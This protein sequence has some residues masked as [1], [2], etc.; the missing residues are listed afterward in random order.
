MSHIKVLKDFLSRI[1]LDDNRA[2]AR[3]ILFLLQVRREMV[4][5]GDYH[6]D[7]VVYRHN[8][9][10][11]SCFDSKEECLQA[12]KDYGHNEEEVAEREDEITKH[13]LAEYWETEQV[14]LTKEGLDR[15]LELNRHNYRKPFR[16]YVIHA[17]RNPEIKELY[18]AIRALVNEHS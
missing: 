17:F 9:M 10:F 3:P 14:F 2:T 15:H 13:Y 18:D 6:Y 16:D 1:D 7:R 5:D 11:E 4:V 8:D 12:L